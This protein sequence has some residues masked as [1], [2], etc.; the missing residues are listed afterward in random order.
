MDKEALAKNS[1]PKLI[2]LEGMGFCRTYK[3]GKRVLKF[4]LPGKAKSFAAM[5]EKWKN[6]KIVPKLY[7][8][9]EDLIVMQWLE[10]KPKLNLSRS[11]LEKLGKVLAKMHRKSKG[12]GK[13]KGKDF[14][15]PNFAKWIENARKEI[16][17]DINERDLPLLSKWFDK[18][19]DFKPQPVLVHGDLGPQHII[20]NKDKPRMIDFENAQSAPAELDIA[21][22]QYTI[23]L[24]NSM[25]KDN[26]EKILKSYGRKINDTLISLLEAYICIKNLN[27]LN[28]IKPKIGKKN[29][30]LAIKLLEIT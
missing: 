1:L 22:L 9:I 4:M 14:E 21:N 29:R 13:P 5:L 25:K 10:G 11:N 2:E 18:I 3:Y 15:F 20:W 24:Y 27:F 28:K 26:F 6:L 8:R 19:K 16:R 17:K 7:G 30:K 23:D 12:F